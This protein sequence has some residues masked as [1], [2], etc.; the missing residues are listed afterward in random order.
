M[1]ARFSLNHGKCAV[2]DRAYSATGN[3]STVVR[4]S[5]LQALEFRVPPCSSGSIR[6]G[7]KLMQVLWNRTCG[8]VN[9]VYSRRIYYR[10][11]A[12]RT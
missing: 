12:V 8:R 4:T 5:M 6:L 2:A 7:T 9:T 11:H 1:T 3:V 10:A